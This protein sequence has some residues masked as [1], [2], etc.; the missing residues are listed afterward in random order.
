M[1]SRVWKSEH[2][3]NQSDIFRQGKA[4]FSP[5]YASNVRIQLKLRPYGAVGLALTS[6][7]R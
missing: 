7:M 1:C 5:K 4:T 3:V 6:R 2:N